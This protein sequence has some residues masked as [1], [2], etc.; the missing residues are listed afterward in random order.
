MA[1]TVIFSADTKNYTSE[2]QKAANVTKSSF[3]DME[4]SSKGAEAAFSNLGGIVKGVIGGYLGIQGVKALASFSIESVK[5]SGQVE[6]MQTAFLNLG[7][8]YG[9]TEDSLKKLKRATD[10][11][12]TS[13]D[14]LKD[15][16]NALLLG[17]V[18][19]DDEMAD[20]FDTAQRLARAVGQDAAYGIESLVTGLGRQSRLMLDN[21]GIIVD[22]EKAYKDYADAIGKTVN[23][24]TEEERKRAFITAG[25]DAA[26]EKVR[27]MGDEQLNSAD[28]IKALSNAW[29][30]FKIAFGQS[31]DVIAD[32][33][34][35]I[36]TKFLNIVTELATPK[37]INAEELVKTMEKQ[38][39]AMQGIAQPEFT[40]SPELLS[41]FE[42][43]QEKLPEQEMEKVE[44]AEKVD[45]TAGFSERQ[46]ENIKNFEAMKA[47]I[48]KEWDDARIQEVAEMNAQLLESE[49]NYLNDV[50]AL[51]KQNIQTTKNQLSWTIGAYDKAF[52]EMGKFGAKFFTG[53]IRNEKDLA[54]QAEIAGRRILQVFLDNIAAKAAARATFE[55]AEAIS[56][57]ATPGMQGFAAGHFASAAKF[58]L[59]AGVATGASAA[60]GAGAP[61]GGGEE[62]PIETTPAIGAGEVSGSRSESISRPAQ[63][64]TIAPV[65]TVNAVAVDKEGAEE[66]FSDYFVPWFSR[67][68]NS[69]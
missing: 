46:L 21:L 64:V 24:L 1:N 52:I 19:S 26:R 22:T 31:M 48:Q 41:I 29:D 61:K 40:V 25:M 15:A 68:D 12:M 69:I 27:Q 67:F 34:L 53:E 39:M 36:L 33:G 9:F 28:K 59:L 56:M 49:Q 45:D 23:A 5:L 30:D 20:L 65:F 13:F 6:T 44:K 55:L 18:D 62:R 16:N 35:P 63:N 38:A 51:R 58:G 42:K 3:Y 2:V 60:I 11:A 14:L 47:S 4:K 50:E 8:Q 43:R 32:K 17:I 7:R 66:F 57:L 37:K 10:N 54:A